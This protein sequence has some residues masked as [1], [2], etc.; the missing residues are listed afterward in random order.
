VTHYLRTVDRQHECKLPEFF[1]GPGDV[2][3][4]EECGRVWEFVGARWQNLWSPFV[5]WK[6][7]SARWAKRQGLGGEMLVN[8]DGSGTADD[9]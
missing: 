8:L 9:D 1:A 6:R 2:V 4:C 3:Q 7:R 5:K